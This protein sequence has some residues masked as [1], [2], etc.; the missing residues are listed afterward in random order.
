MWT[1]PEWSTR[2]QR[3]SG[4]GSATLNNLTLVF[5]RAD[6]VR[7]KQQLRYAGPFSLVKRG[8]KNLT[9]DVV[10]LHN[11]ASIDRIKPDTAGC[12]LTAWLLR[13]HK[14]HHFEQFWSLPMSPVGTSGEDR[15]T[16]SPI[17]PEMSG[18]QSG[19]WDRKLNQLVRLSDFYLVPHWV[20]ECRSIC[21]CTAIMNRITSVYCETNALRDMNPARCAVR[22]STGRVLDNRHQVGYQPVF[23]STII[24]S[25]CFTFSLKNQ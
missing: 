4:Y 12:R 3:F 7:L 10:G 9:L 18:T 14:F 11:R 16:T 2:G 6:N 17:E 20:V 19:H 24:K 15:D 1:L 5:V 13:S 23:T 25:L 22:S 21:K 8:L